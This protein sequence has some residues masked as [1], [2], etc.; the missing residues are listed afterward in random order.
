MS[1]GISSLP[2][3]LEARCPVRNIARFYRI[4]TGR[5]LFGWLVVECSWGRIGTTG[6]QRR[7]AF[8][9]ERDAEA[10]LRQKLARRATARRRIGV[11]YRPA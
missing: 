5:D 2:L 9:D 1:A 8:S 3:A 4:E 6:R 11:E 7:A 10:F